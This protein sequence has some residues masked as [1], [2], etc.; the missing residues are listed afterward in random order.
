[1]LSLVNM[2]SHQLCMEPTDDKN[3]AYQAC[4]I[5]ELISELLLLLSCLLPISEGL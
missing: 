5:T 1:M 2:L 3:N 4:N